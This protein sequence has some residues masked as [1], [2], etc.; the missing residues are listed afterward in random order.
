LNT[1][2]VI[3]AGRSEAAGAA[4]SPCDIWRHEIAREEYDVRLAE[5]LAHNPDFG[6]L[7]CPVRPDETGPPL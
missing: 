5:A 2:A 1:V 7:G 3:D 4:T 6:A